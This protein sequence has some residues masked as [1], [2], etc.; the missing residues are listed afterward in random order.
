MEHDMRPQQA[1]SRLFES[2]T[3][4][5]FPAARAAIA[6]GADPNAKDDDQRTPLHVAVLCG[7]YDLARLL[8][9]KGA[10]PNAKDKM[11]RTPLYLAAEYGRTDLVELLRCAPKAQSSHAE[12]LAEQPGGDEQLGGR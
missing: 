2:A 4:G 5:D 3:S 1:T 6:A 9:E 12:R 10:A 7:K 11:Q 8:V